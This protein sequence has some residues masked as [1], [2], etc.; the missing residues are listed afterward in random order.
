VAIK[1][2]CRPRDD[3]SDAALKKHRVNHA[4]RYGA[5]GDDKNR[6]I[7]RRPQLHEF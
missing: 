7:A 2:I 4:N 5:F 6:T 1:H 3:A